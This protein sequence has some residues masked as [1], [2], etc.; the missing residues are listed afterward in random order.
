MGYHQGYHLNLN[1]DKG[2][3]RVLYSRDKIALLIL[4]DKFFQ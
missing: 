3:N 2:S 1:G 4:V